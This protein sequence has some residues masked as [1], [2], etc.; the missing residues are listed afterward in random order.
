MA[1]KKTR[2]FFDLSL[3]EK[4]AVVTRLAKGTNYHQTRPLSRK[5]KALW[6]A[7]KR[8]RGRPPKSPETKSSRVNLT[9]DPVLLAK[10]NAYAKAKGISRAELVAR[11]VKLAMAI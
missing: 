6:E 10:M 3:A 11:G 8:G 5:E 7:A 2:S 4:E 1:V 9:F